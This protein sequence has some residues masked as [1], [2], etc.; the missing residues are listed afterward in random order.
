MEEENTLNQFDLHSNIV[1]IQEFKKAV[2][3]LA[4]KQESY[5]IKHYGGEQSAI[6][7]GTIFKYSEDV[8]KMFV[9]DLKGDVSNHDFYIEQF[10][11][12]IVRGGKIKVLIQDDANV[13]RSKVKELLDMYSSMKASINI[14]ETNRKFVIEENGEEKEIHF[15]IGDNKYIR[16]E[17]DIEKYSGVA[18][19]NSPEIVKMLDTQFEAI[20]Q[21]AKDE[22]TR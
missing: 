11:N 18:S 17:D 15:A 1:N 19:F 22:I 20:Y 5:P 12:F 9:G 13:Q 4:K 14:I 7:L 8:V 3:L 2:D 10:K 16:I 21:E 6:V